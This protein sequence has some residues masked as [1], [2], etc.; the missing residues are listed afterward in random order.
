MRLFA[1]VYPP[2]EALDDIA[3]QVARLHVGAAAASGI[4]VRITA[5]DTLHVTIVFLGEVDDA[6]L[7]DVTAAFG[8]AAGTWRRHADAFGFRDGDGPPR[9]RLAG[10]GRFGRGRFTVLWAG[11]AGDVA[12][13]RALHAASRRELRR[14]RL[15]H[16]WRPF[17]PHVTLARP[18]DRVS[19]EAVAADREVLDGYFGPSWPVTELVLMRSHLGS[20]PTYERIAAWNL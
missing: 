7:P 4:N 19:P 1:A 17:R 18:G 12:V 13:L 10:G 20:R 14:G 9:I 8:R 6:R 15:P 3:G 11:L 5:R 16:D 2:P